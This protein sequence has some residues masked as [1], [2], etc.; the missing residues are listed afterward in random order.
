M[1]KTKTAEQGE[2][3]EF[4]RLL[5]RFCLLKLVR[6]GA[7]WSRHGT[8]WAPTSYPFSF[9]AR[10]RACLS[11]SPLPFRSPFI[12]AHAHIG[13][14]AHAPASKLSAAAV[15]RV[16]LLSLTNLQMQAL[17]RRQRRILPTCSTPPAHP[18]SPNPPP[19]H[20]H[21]RAALL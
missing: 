19:T 9:V 6:C 7:L 8:Y 16:V 15:E 13:K 18:T 21:G 11:S 17:A 12:H 1:Y 2:S 3:C 14:A 20:R 10:L 4:H 5:S